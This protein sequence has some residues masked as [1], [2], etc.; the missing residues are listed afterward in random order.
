M[1]IKSHADVIDAWGSQAGLAEA[2]KVTEGRVAN[3]KWRNNIPSEYWFAL[4]KQAK[5]RQL[6]GVTLEVLARTH[7]RLHRF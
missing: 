3:W 4:V 5:K 7:A 6:E 2:I 1:R